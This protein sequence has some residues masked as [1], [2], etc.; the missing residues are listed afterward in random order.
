M[1]VN[2][3][4]EY[5]SSIARRAGALLAQNGHVSVHQRTR[6]TRPRRSASDSGSEFSQ[7]SNANEGA[8]TPTRS[9]PAERSIDLRLESILEIRASASALDRPSEI[10][11]SR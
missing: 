1:T 11:S 2:P 9:L 7:P 4:A 3:Q 6:T 10:M 8:A 5:C